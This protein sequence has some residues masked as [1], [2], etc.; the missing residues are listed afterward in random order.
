MVSIATPTSLL[1]MRIFFSLVD[2]DWSVANDFLVSASSD[3]TARLWD[4]N[5]GSCLREISE[6]GG[7]RSLCC[8]FHP[9]NNNLV[10]VSLM[11]SLCAP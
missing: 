6:G 1:Q 3:G 5:T 9:N 10:V 4:P 7:G 2:F 11:M 8:R